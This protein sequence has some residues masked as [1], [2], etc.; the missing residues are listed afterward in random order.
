MGSIKNKQKI[1]N[2]LS[3][4]KEMVQ[5][6]K[7][8]TID[9][10]RLKKEIIEKTK[11][12]VEI[13]D[14]ELGQILKKYDKI[15]FDGKYSQFL[16]QENFEA[17][18]LEWI[19]QVVTQEK[20]KLDKNKIK[21]KVGHLVA[22]FDRYYPEISRELLNNYDELFEEQYKK[23]IKLERCKPLILSY[24]NRE[25]NDNNQQNLQKE[26]IKEKIKKK[27]QSM[28]SSQSIRISVDLQD[29][30]ENY[31]LIFNWIY[32]ENIENSRIARLLKK[33]KAGD[34]N[35]II[36]NGHNRD[37][38]IAKKAMTDIQD[39]K[40]D[41]LSRIKTGGIGE[42]IDNFEKNK[43]V[44]KNVKERKELEYTTIRG[45]EIIF[46]N[47]KGKKSNP[48]SGEIK[49]MPFMQEE[50]QKGKVISYPM[51]SNRRKHEEEGEEE[52]WQK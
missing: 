6:R 11:L 3:Q 7:E 36:T 31:D 9:F 37:L 8:E 30:L 19:R 40:Q 41:F 26:T 33:Q 32:E 24:L 50:R 5:S 10:I 42:D 51:D 35:K 28:D 27:I 22:E 2:I 49:I 13:T 16:E 12:G 14:N 25:V 44:S 38:E 1:E 39:K 18:I 43:K 45:D 17:K 48:I 29:V 34:I 23:F 20:E 52:R 15:L 47:N 46:H 4:I 21:E